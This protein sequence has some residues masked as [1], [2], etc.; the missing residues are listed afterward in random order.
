MAGSFWNVIKAWGPGVVTDTIVRQSPTLYGKTILEDTV[1][2]GFGTTDSAYL[3]D[4][5]LKITCNVGDRNLAIS[6]A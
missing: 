6:T 2:D 4:A 5:R 1:F 3:Y